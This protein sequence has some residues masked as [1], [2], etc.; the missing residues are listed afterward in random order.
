MPA[1][2]VRVPA[3][4]SRTP[5]TQPQTT[6]QG[7]ARIQ[8]RKGRFAQGE[9]RPGWHFFSANEVVGQDTPRKPFTPCLVE[10]Q[11]LV[12]KRQPA[13]GIHAGKPIQKRL[14]Q[15]R[16]RE[17]CQ[18]RTPLVTAATRLFP[19]FPQRTQFRLHGRLVR[20]RLHGEVFC[21]KRRRYTLGGKVAGCQFL[22][23]GLKGAVS[24][25]P[26]I[27]E[28]DGGRPGSQP[29]G[30]SRTSRRNEKAPHQPHH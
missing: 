17:P 28:F 22:F 14:H 19:G 8:R 2:P 30:D 5:Q 21:R 7:Q 24:R 23:V 15:G 27:D 26:C 20:Q 10:S 1:L 25:T 4:Q 16:R 11:H 29:V 13:V 12:V 9:A 18:A 3:T 6:S